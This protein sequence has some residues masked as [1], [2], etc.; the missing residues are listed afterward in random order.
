MQPA[1]PAAGASGGVDL[2]GSGGGAAAASSSGESFSF[3]SGGAGFA[4]V[5]RSRKYNHCPPQNRSPRIALTDGFVDIGPGLAPSAAKRPAPDG[6]SA[7]NGGQGQ[8]KK[9]KKKKNKKKGG[10]KEPERFSFK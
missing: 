7:E 10:A 3:A 8:K 5:Q 4:A 1:Q 2:L 6:E 9:K